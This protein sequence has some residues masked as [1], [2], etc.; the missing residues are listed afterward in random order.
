MRFKALPVLLLLGSLLGTLGNDKLAADFAEPPDSARTWT[1]WHWMNG[2]VTREGITADLEAMAR[3]GI[4]G[5]QMFDVSAQMGGEGPVKYLSPEWLEMAR[6]SASEAKRLGLEL[7]FHNC[8]GWSSSGGPWVKAEQSMQVLTTSRTLAHGPSTFDSVLPQPP[9]NLD[10]Y[11]DSAVVA[12][13]MPENVIG[14]KE[15]APVITASADGFDPAVLLDGR[16]DTLVKL[17][18][19]TAE[20][21]QFIDVAF[22]SPYTARA[23]SVDPGAY[24]QGYQGVLQASDDGKQYRTV[25]SWDIQHARG[26]RSFAFP[27]TTSRF[28]RVVFI[29]PARDNYSCLNV[30][31]VDLVSEFEI[32]DWEQKAGF[33]AYVQK[34]GAP[35]LSENAEVIPADRVIDLTSKMDKSGRLRW[36]VPAGN[37]AILRLGHTPLSKGV[38]S[39]NPATSAGKGLECDKLDA[40][41]VRAF[42]NGGPAKIIDALRPYVGTTVTEILIDSYERGQPN[43]TAKLPKEFEERRG[44]NMVKYMPVLTGRVVGS[45]EES[46]RFLWDVRQTIG[47]LFAENYAGTF[48]QLAKEN[49]LRFA[50]EGGALVVDQMRYMGFADMPTSEI[51]VKW[52][53]PLASLSASIAHVYGRT[54]VGNETMTATPENERWT[55]DP[56]SLKALGDGIFCSGI[57]RF[58]FHTFTHQPWPGREPGFT[59]GKWGSH[60]DGTNTWWN[61]GAEWRR[62]LARCQYLLQQGVYVADAL[63]FCGEN[64]PTGKTSLNIPPGYHYDTCNADVL[65]HRLAVKDGRL[66]LPN[67]ASYAYLALGDV[68]EMTLPVLKKI[69]QLVQDGA[70]IEGERTLKSQGLTGYPESDEE[71][72]RIAA[73]L[74]GT[75]DTTAEHSLGKGRVFTGMDAAAVFKKLNLPPDIQYS[76]G[77]EDLRF[78]H[79]RT[80]EAEI[81]FVSNQ[82][83]A[84][85]QVDATF[86]VQGRAPELWDAETGRTE[87]APVFREISDGITVPLNFSPRGSVF[88]IFRRPVTEPHLVAATNAALLS[89][90]GTNVILT[91][92]ENGRYDF[93]SSGGNASHVEIDQIPGPLPI[94]GPW[95]IAFP[96]KLGAPEKAVFEKLISWPESHDT[97]IKYFAGTATYG[98]TVDLPADRLGKEKRLYLD[99]GEVRNLARVRINGKDLGILWKPPFR[100]DITSAA[101]A[102]KN[103]LQVEVTNLWPNRLIGDEQLPPDCEWNPDGGLAKLPDWFVAGEKRPTGRIAFTTWRHWKK[104]DQLLPSGLLGPVRVLSAQTTLLH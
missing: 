70:T 51:W 79:L 38:N 74:W 82:K 95:Q 12:Y 59:M 13:P 17:P 23:F 58:L 80:D 48:A 62:Y 68:R 73:E 18:L 49:K 77:N 100:V 81:Y 31:D 46:E 2:Y 65:L 98:N 63:I 1:W 87:S 56:Y 9:T 91:A 26:S 5:A 89:M 78:I 76:S 11:Q 47:D 14:L 32:D 34:P 88:V 99:L 40:D 103:S 21:P 67:G 36:E 101:H 93:R 41:A 97:G 64:V 6:F 72:R 66:T 71:V 39:N 96:P 60:L 25:R 20:H 3:G 44:Y 35:Q 69:R 10:C 104:D 30:A 94:D 55:A 4:G 85:L 24:R 90:A 7:G 43:W 102:G 22:A 29:K 16:P 19:P 45:V 54:L 27:A 33:Q 53:P 15:A 86:R 8:S 28:F 75:E 37:W 52:N 42:W 61:Q 57:N 92:W 83:D 84:P 50:L